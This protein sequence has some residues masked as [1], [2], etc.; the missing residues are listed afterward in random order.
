MLVGRLGPRAFGQAQRML[1]DAAEAQDVT[2]E[3]LMRLWKLAPDWQQGGARVTTWLYRVVA[4][5][6]T[7]R[8][9]RR[10]SLP[11][12]ATWDVPDSAPLPEERILQ[13]ARAQALSSALALLPD[14]QAQAVAL[15]HLEGLSLG[16]IAEIMDLGYEAVESLVARGRRGLSAAL[17]GRRMALGFGDE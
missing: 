6:C 4:N 7:D 8:L 10:P 3:A 12:D 17:A 1:G 13:E 5:L 11:L 15:R 16:E 14:R 2:Q 9:R